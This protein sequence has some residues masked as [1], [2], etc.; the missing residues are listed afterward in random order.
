MRVVNIKSMAHD[1]VLI[2]EMYTPCRACLLNSSILC[3]YA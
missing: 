3:L 2:F 1:S